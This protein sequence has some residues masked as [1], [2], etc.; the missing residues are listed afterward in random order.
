MERGK[1]HKLNQK[2][3]FF[4]IDLCIITLT[5]SLIVVETLKSCSKSSWSTPHKTLTCEEKLNK[6]QQN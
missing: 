4:E 1:K 2:W 5:A 6:I 3:N